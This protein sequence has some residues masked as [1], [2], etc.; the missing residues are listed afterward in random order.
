MDMVSGTT[1][2][3]S[4][5]RPEPNGTPGRSVVKVGSFQTVHHLGMKN[6]QNLVDA[7]YTALSLMQSQPLL[8]LSKYLLHRPQ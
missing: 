6:F 4:A 5:T 3:H 2:L 1:A 8:L 7:G